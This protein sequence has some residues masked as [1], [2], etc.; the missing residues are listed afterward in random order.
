M[1][2]LAEVY[3]STVYYKSR[4]KQLLKGHVLIES[5]NGSDLAGNMYRIASRLF[6]D[7]HYKVYIV[8]KPDSREKLERLINGRADT[9]VHGSTK[10]YRLLARAE[11]LF[12][13]STF[14][15]RFIKRRGQIYTNTWHGTPLK[16]MGKHVPD[17]V[18][19][20]GNVQRNLSVADYLVFQGAHMYERMNEAYEL[21]LLFK[22]SS[23]LTGYPRNVVFFDEKQR[24]NLRKR[25]GFLKKQIIVY[26]PTW[27][28]RLTD[29]KASEQQKELVSFLDGLDLLL[30]DEQ[31]FFV[32]LHLYAEKGM[33][34]KEYKHIR[35]FPEE[36]ELYS[37][38]NASDC[39][40]TDYSS[41]MFDYADSGRNIVL[42]TKDDKSYKKTR[43][44][45]TDIAELPF[46]RTYT[47]QELAEALNRQNKPT[48]EFIKSFCT[49]DT[50]KADIDVCRA[51]F[52]T[53]LR[54]NEREVKAVY[55]E[56]PCEYIKTN[57]CGEDELICFKGDILKGMP[58]EAAAVAKKAHI[59]PVDSGRFYTF[60][61]AFALLLQKLMG[62]EVMKRT[63]AALKRRE[64]ERHFGGMNIKRVTDEKGS[65]IYEED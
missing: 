54:K 45:Y 23:L 47:A 65:I 50:S 2:K 34:L 53:K 59:M 32:K 29:I 21:P 11:Y 63:M 64:A 30:K 6:E 31:I 27:R 7:Y 20:M 36:Y 55:T 48:E 57:A 51:V 16:R 37:F 10:Y 24:N 14:E 19:A 8:V 15:Y 35:S 28:G 38:L 26:M 62:R 3:K 39:L 46:E 40:V 13:D 5:K 52:E 60:R 25:L 17:R 44:L 41:V 58:A 1:H 18:Y 22:G 43:G 33:K 42:F 49:Y 4:E 9:V 61:E 56:K 12:N